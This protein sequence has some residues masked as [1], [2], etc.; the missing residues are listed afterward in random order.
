MEDNHC[1]YFA[2]G[3]HGGGGCVLCVH[4]RVEYNQQDQSIVCPASVGAKLFDAICKPNL[5][6]G[7]YSMHLWWPLQQVPEL[8]ANWNI[9]CLGLTRERRH[10]DMTVALDFYRHLDA[11]LYSRR[12]NLAY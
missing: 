5:R 11:F 10:M 12:S 4:A 2:I 7:L 3:T 9:K 1:L 8:V 6:T